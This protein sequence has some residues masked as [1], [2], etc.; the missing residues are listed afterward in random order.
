MVSNEE[1]V[2]LYKSTENEKSKNILFNKILQKNISGIKNIVHF[3]N[4][5]N[6][7]DFFEELMQEASIYLIHCIDKYNADSEVL[8]W[9]FTYNC[10]RNKLYKVYNKMLSQ[11]KRESLTANIPDKRYHCLEDSYLNEDLDK[12]FKKEFMKKYLNKVFK[13]GKNSKKLFLLRHGLQ[14]NQPMTYN[15]ISNICGVSRQSIQKTCARYENKIK[16]LIEEDIASGKITKE[17]LY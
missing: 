9:T 2:K 3:Y 6:N 13:K 11:V 7:Y 17:D 8:F 1:L 5:L 14:D 16:K 12:N 15:L 10:M 4:R